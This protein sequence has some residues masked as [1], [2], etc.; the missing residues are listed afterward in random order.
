MESMILLL[1]SN[2]SRLGREHIISGKK[3]N[4]LPLIEIFFIDLNFIKVWG[5]EARLLWD[6]NK[7]LRLIQFPI[8]SGIESIKL[9]PIFNS[10]R[11][12]RRL[13]ESGICCNLF[14]FK[15]SL[16]NWAK[17]PIDPEAQ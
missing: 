16:F 1:I 4:L 7:I 6:A 3:V 2:S 13:I 11:F 15:L 8:N 17:F 14:P 5:K 9:S 10:S 12:S